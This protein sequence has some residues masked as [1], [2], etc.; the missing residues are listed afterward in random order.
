MHIVAR[1]L[2]N[3]SQVMA[4]QIGVDRWGNQGRGLASQRVYRP[5]DVA[6]FVLGLPHRTRPA[7]AFGPYPR[8]CALLSDA[9]LILEPD[10]DALVGVLLLHLADKKGARWTHS[11]IASGSL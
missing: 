1:F 7:A 4:H 9:C 11:R 3:H 2:R 10:G 6:P 8:Q 5:E